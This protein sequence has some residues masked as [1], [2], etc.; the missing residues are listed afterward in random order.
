MDVDRE[1]VSSCCLFLSEISI[2]TSI[3]KCLNFAMNIY[4]FS[5][6]HP[7]FL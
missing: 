1:L 5:L 7:L 3:S 4:D 6:P 2:Y